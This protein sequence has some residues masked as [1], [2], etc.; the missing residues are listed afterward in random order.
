[1]AKRPLAKGVLAISIV[2]TAIAVQATPA[3]ATASRCSP[4]WQDWGLGGRTSWYCHSGSGYYR[5]LAYCA[6][7]PQGTYGGA[8]YF[9][10]WEYTGTWASTAT[11]PANKYL[12][13]GGYDLA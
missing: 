11:C 7:N 10:P 4:D 13:A 3:A 12:I 5:A 1:M 6:Y 9:G 8:Y 2:A